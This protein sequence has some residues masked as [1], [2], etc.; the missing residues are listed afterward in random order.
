MT[1]DLIIFAA[2]MW[3]GTIN[4]LVGSGALATFPTLLFLGYPA[5]VANVSNNIGVVAGGLSGIHGYRHE[6]RG[7]LPLLRPL[8]PASLLGG[9]AGRCCCSPF[10]RIPSSP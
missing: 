2:G 5:L 6:L 8:L 1:H 9:I 4:V 10:H 7:N 3:A